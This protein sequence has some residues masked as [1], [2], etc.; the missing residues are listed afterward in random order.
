MSKNWDQVAKGLEEIDFA[1]L[2]HDE[3][4]ALPTSIIRMCSELIAAVGLGEC[5]PKLANR[6]NRVINRLNREMDEELK[7]EGEPTNED[8]V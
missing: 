5:S 6:I 8:Q 2:A 1:A 4:Q 7:K 3:K